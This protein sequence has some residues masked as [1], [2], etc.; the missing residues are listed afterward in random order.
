MNSRQ[1]R[2]TGGLAAA[3]A[4]AEGVAKAGAASASGKLGRGLSTA[5]ET[6]AKAGAAGASPKAGA[7]GASPKAG[8]AGASGKLG[9]N[10]SRTLFSTPE[11]NAVAPGLSMEDMQKLIADRL[12]ERNRKAV[13]Q[14][15][16]ALSSPEPIPLGREE[17]K[18]MIRNQ[19][20]PPPRTPPPS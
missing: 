3:G 11:A 4:G 16:K 17:I 10:F 19:A 9:K 2:Q 5:G 13:G 7:A 6:V 1:R 12:G 8:A 20:P 15:A 14:Q 18:N